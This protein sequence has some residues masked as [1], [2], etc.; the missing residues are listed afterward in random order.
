MYI[1]IYIYIY[2]SKKG[3]TS[4]NVS[5]NLKMKSIFNET[6]KFSLRQILSLLRF[7]SCQNWMTTA[8]LVAET[9]LKLLNERVLSTEEPCTSKY[10]TLR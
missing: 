7:G 5:V 9:Q 6:S 3:K 1:Y 8:N 4:A 2:I 10:V